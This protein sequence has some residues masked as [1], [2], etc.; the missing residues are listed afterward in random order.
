[1]NLKIIISVFVFSL[2][3][4]LGVSNTH[5]QT[6]TAQS[7]QPIDIIVESDSIAEETLEESTASGEQDEIDKLTKEDIT[8]PE[9][10][11]EKSE[12]LDL[13][14]NRPSRYFVYLLSLMKPIKKLARCHAVNQQVVAA[15]KRI[16][17]LLDEPV[18]IMEAPD[19][20]KI[21]DIQRSITLD[22]VSFE[23]DKDK[24]ILNDVSLEIKAGEIV[25]FVGQSGVGKTTLVN[26]VPRFYDPT[27][28][29]VKING[30]DIR[31][32]TLKS[33]RN[34]I[35]IVAQETVLFN[36]TVRENI[37]YHNPEAPLEQV[38]KAAVAANASGFIESL[39]KGYDTSLGERGMKLS[40]GQ[41][42]RISI[43]RAIFKDP[44][45]LI[46]DEAT[47]HLDTESEREVQAAIENLMRG[48]TVFVI[49]HRLSTIQRANRIIVLSDGKIIQEGTNDS[50]LAQD[51]AYKRLYDL[52]FNI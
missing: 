13:F 49:A 4:T 28:G 36:G 3:S 11:E 8:K 38:K 7:P 14:E 26:L 22:H 21:T 27:D 29:A 48:R 46:L 43:A 1:M 32:M 19:A 20:Q 12:I 18:E 10:P 30:T 51:G 40:G 31:D 41:R 2:F 9:E 16:F 42:Q 23:Y 35:G 6:R 37:A 50:L 45:I 39:P 47:S 15:G 5:A 17:M 44:P 25:A 33:L 24:Q 52:Q 34:L